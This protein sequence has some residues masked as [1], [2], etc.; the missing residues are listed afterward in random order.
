MVWCWQEVGFFGAGVIE[1]LASPGCNP[2]L[3]GKQMDNQAFEGKLSIIIPA[4]NE[5]ESIKDSI[6]VTIRFL[7]KSLPIEYRISL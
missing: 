2:I 4:Y 3:E 7:D 6:R 5:G 1:K